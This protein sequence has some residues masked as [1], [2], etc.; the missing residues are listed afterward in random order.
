MH[1]CRSSQWLG[2]LVSVMSTLWNRTD[3][4][5]CQP[6]ISKHLQPESESVTSELF[7]PSAGGET[8][9]VRFWNKDKMM[10]KTWRVQDPSSVV[11]ERGRER[12]SEKQGQR[13]QRSK[14]GNSSKEHRSH[15]NTEKQCSHTC[16]HTSSSVALD[17]TSWQRA[18]IH[19]SICLLG[20]LTY[21]NTRT[22][23]LTP[24]N[25]HSQAHTETAHL[26]RCLSLQSNFQVTPIFNSIRGDVKG[27]IR[28][29]ELHSWVLFFLLLLIAAISGHVGERVPDSSSSYK[30]AH[31]L[32]LRSWRPRKYHL[33]CRQMWDVV[34]FKGWMSC[35]PQTGSCAFVFSV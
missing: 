6:E 31:L 21:A 4:F 12:E 29:D 17:W 32:Y 27:L 30:W 22:S 35:A 11:K 23:A 25:T 8:N 7:H 1:C 16:V 26:R 18:Y 10:N 14:N 13:K 3:I 15:N 20:I 24:T 9:P 2:S 28:A 33:L 34:Y 5:S 19:V